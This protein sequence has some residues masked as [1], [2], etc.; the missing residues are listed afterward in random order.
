MKER[1]A[2]IGFN[3]PYLYDESQ[4]IGRTLGATVTPHFFVFDKNRKLVY[5]G[6]LDDNQ[7]QNK[8]KS[9]YLEDAVSAAL[10]AEK[11]KTAETAARG[12]AVQYQ[13]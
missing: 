7:D 5:M 13:K 11:P 8:A 9:A 10:K 3:F 1:A 4:S 6:A 2:E 12:C